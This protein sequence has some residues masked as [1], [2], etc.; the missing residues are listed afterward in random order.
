MNER[1]NERTG[2]G[3]GSTQQ[4]GGKKEETR[5]IKTLRYAKHIVSLHL[6]AP[7]EKGKTFKMCLL[8]C[9]FSLSSPRFF[10]F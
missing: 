6:L 3:E 9:L 4:K 1:T 7:R 8:S 5:L 2:V 10:F